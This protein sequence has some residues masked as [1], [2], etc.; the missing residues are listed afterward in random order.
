[1][2][3]T[4]RVALGAASLRGDPEML[5]PLRAGG[6]ELL[7]APSPIPSNSGQRW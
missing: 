1:M 7:A 5:S 3:M 4:R 2:K 6:I